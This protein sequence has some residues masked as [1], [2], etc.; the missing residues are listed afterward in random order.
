MANRISKSM[1]V[2]CNGIVTRLKIRERKMKILSSAPAYR[3][4]SRFANFG[5]IFGRGE[6]GAFVGREEE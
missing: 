3:V 4:P 5:C 2:S 1:I 6:V